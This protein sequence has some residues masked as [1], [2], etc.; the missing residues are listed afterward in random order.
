MDVHSPRLSPD[1]RWF[2]FYAKTSATARTM[3]VAP[4]RGEREI[5]EKDWIAVTDG[6]QLDREPHWSSDGRLLYFFSER[7]GSRCIW[8]L[9]LDAA[10]K[11]PAGA[12]FPV[13]HSHDASRS[14]A[15]TGNRASDAGPAVAKN[16]VIFAMNEMTGSIW[17]TRLKL[18]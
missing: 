15:N 13:Y 4:F 14:I 5:P 11:R 1:E 9:R 18:D 12:P 6:T 8:A 7:D 17:M 2:T 3:Y 16:Q 10:T